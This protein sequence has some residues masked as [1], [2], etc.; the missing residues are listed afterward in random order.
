MK[1]AS[2][3]SIIFFFFSPFTHVIHFTRTIIN[4]KSEEWE[5][6]KELHSRIHAR[7]LSRRQILVIILLP[8]KKKI[9]IRK[10]K[11]WKTTTF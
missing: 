11:Q 5:Q 7:N 1:I 3:K 4:N 8:E 9:R 2:F 10:R 6:A